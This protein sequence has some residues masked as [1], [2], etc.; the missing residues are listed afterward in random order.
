MCNLYDYISVCNLDGIA[1]SGYLPLIK[2]AHQCGTKVHGLGVNDNR[3]LRQVPFDSV[4][5]SVWISN[6]HWGYY[7]N[8][9]IPKTTENNKKW[10]GIYER[11]SFIEELNRQNFFKEYWKSYF[12]M[13]RK[14]L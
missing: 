11:H 12:T 1:R 7:G 3:L 13:Y 14:P 9:E 6:A 4:D 5:S 8:K 2:Y 10:R